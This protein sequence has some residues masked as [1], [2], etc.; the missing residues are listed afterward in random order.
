MPNE[1]VARNGIIALSNTTISGSLSVT[2]N[3]SGSIFTGSF[4]G[5]LIGTSSQALTA[6]FIQASGVIGLN[7]SQI[8]TGSVTASV[9]DGS[10]SF[11]ITS[12]SSTLLFVSRSGNV[13]IGTTTP[14][15][16]TDIVGSTTGDGG[17][18]NGTGA[19]LR[20]KQNTSWSASQP[21]ALYV[22]GYSYLNGFRINASDGIRALL[23]TSAGGQLGF[24]TTGNDPIT[25]TQLDATERMRIAAG[26]NVGIGITSPTAL[27]HV[28]G[29][30]GTLLQTTSGS[31]TGLFVS[32]SG[33]VGVGNTNPTH[34]LD[35]TTNKTG[36]G[37]G[38]TIRINRLDN[39][40]YENAINWA[41]GGTN[42][43]F[44]GS[45]N[46]STDNFY[47][48]NWARSA[49][50][51]T[52]L[53]TSGN[54]G[55][56]KT[57]PNT[58]LDVNGN[59][60]ISGSL[61]VTGSITAQTLIV[62]TVSSSIIYSSGSNIFGN[63][64]TDTQQF[65]GSV[66]VSGSIT[67]SG[68]VTNNLTASYALNADALD[69]INSTQLATTGSNI[70]R[71]NQSITGS[72]IV[73]SSTF[74]T[75]IIGSGSGV[76]TVDGTSGRLFSV[77]DSLSGSLFSVN[78]AAGLPVIEA[79]SDNTVRIGQFGR[80][81]L[82]VSQSAIGIG[83][84]TGIN[85]VLDI[86][87][88]VVITGSLSVSGSI[89][90]NLTS[91]FAI[92]ASY[93]SN[94]DAGYAKTFS[95]LTPAVTWSIIH[96]LNSLVPLIQV[97]D[98]N[99]SQ[100]IPASIVNTSRSGSS[101]TFA[102]SQAGY[103]VISTG[104]ITVT[105]S[106]AILSQTTPSATWSFAHNLNTQ[107]PVFTVFDS[108]N[109]VIMPLQINATNANSASIYFSSPQIGTAVAANGGVGAAASNNATASFTN[110]STWT[111]NHNL[112]RQNII[113]QT[114]DSSYNQI[115]PQ[116]IQL[117]SINTAV[118]T[119]PSNT[120][121]YAIASIG[122]VTGQA[123]SASY[124]FTSSY[125]LPL[126]QDIS[127]TGS[128]RMSGSATFGLASAV[129]IDTD[130]TFGQDY[131]T[132][133]FG[134]RSN[135]FNRIY[136]RS[137]TSDGLYL[138]AATGRGI[139]LRPNGANISYLI[140][141]SSG[142]VGIGP[143]LLTPQA[144]LHVSG[145]TGG[146]FEVDGAASVNALYV[147]ASGDVGIGK[148]APNARLD[149]SG[150][151]L[152]SGSITT[153][154]T[155]TAQTLVV[156]TVTSSVSFITGSTKFG[157]LASNTHQFTGSVLVS[158]SLTSTG[159]GLNS[160]LRIT[161]TT[162]TTGVDWHLY[163]LN[164]GNF[165]LYNN[166][167]GAYALQISSSGNVGIGTATPTRPLFVN[168]SA[169]FDN[170]GD[171]STTNPS[172][173]IGST[174][175][176]FSYIAGG[177]LSLL[178]GAT[179][180]MRIVPSGH[181]HIKNRVA[182]DSPVEFMFNSNYDNNTDLVT[183]AGYIARIEFLNTDGI[184]RFQTGTSAASVS[185]GS[186]PAFSDRL[187]ITPAGKILIGTS[188][189]VGQQLRIY[190]AT[191]SEWNIKLV[192]PNGSN[193]LFQEF[194]TTTDSDATA[195]ARGSITYNGTNVLYTG[196]S[197]YRLKEDLKEYNGLSIISQLKTYDFKWKEA[198]TRDY[199]MMAHELQEILPNVVTG[200]KDALNEDNSIK[201]QG[202]DYSKLVPILIK[203]IQE[204]TARIEQLENK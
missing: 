28:S 204:L 186:V 168:G 144:S 36:N 26:G 73:S 148:I 68:S 1:F 3:I 108:S 116:N 199:G 92:S 33:F 87:G 147:S 141:S 143:N 38:S 177:A 178:T 4:V 83:K 151:V 146:V 16:L 102:T 72:L 99:Y 190:Q 85:G 170:N 112:N 189:N 52:V 30:S 145:T 129:T 2:N 74:A 55:I 40:S 62:Q 152:I 126:V 51:I 82:F 117:T 58:R 47:L 56:G 187:T 165:G 155:I 200:E 115:I 192:Q 153:T 175:V 133:G 21:W 7:L 78:T 111:F 46:D 39:S 6:S 71:G 12:G 202:V 103:A 136:G 57:A 8:A 188:T 119:F 17:S 25:F 194:L 109:N 66:L 110:S 128:L 70:F 196:T 15:N 84:E 22:E 14:N 172:I 98:L 157:S 134:G 182:F 100:I 65:T 198:G 139:F 130:G 60:L 75:A 158:G 105:G 90:N 27:L 121:G 41:T 42:K 131:G 123:V 118:I 93:A 63:K 37:A 77:D 31:T 97:Y 164:N 91:S 161:N 67:V 20:V 203:S 19:I 101:I 11:A 120:S 154:G 49:F 95:Q 113:V 184:I 174:N 76:F 193:Q 107:F 156:Q 169:F 53:S 135:G 104:G 64:A 29:T 179:E 173:A 122:G 89:V 13:G 180:R 61:T 162:A 181:L 80:R 59:T 5:N 176:G 142:A 43:W 137:N 88:S 171:G 167:G 183:A 44:L 132:I 45:D 48:Y 150:S 166:T 140:V 32:S 197:D 34:M 106:N 9:S 24:A 160:S 138:G 195:T 18:F 114:Y 163:S 201:P 79:F 127:I 96:D 23:K 125:V 86:S 159:T 185:S 54:V 50:E 81:A 191:T 94:F 10:G 149:V 124:A 69:G 35:I